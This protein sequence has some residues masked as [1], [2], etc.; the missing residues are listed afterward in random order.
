[1]H[2]VKP[3]IEAL[4]E[5]VITYAME[6]LRMD[7]PTLDQPLSEKALTKRAGETITEKAWGAK[8]Y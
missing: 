1:M 4:S 5:S 6:R 7:P 3:D 2:Q 8:R